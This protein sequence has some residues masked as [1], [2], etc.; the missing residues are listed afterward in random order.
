M[1]VVRQFGTLD[2][3]NIS[4]KINTE[5]GKLYKEYPNGDLVD[6]KY[7]IDTD[8]Y[9]SVLIIF[10]TEKPEFNPLILNQIIESLKG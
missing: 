1:K 7:L 2:Y 5:L 4:E 8:N 10:E 6:I 9:Y 3:K